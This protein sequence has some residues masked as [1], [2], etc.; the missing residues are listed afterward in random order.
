M[1]ALSIAHFKRLE[2]RDMCTDQAPTLSLESR[3]MANI[4]G[5]SVPVTT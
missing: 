2:I 3:A 1:A 4:E 5:K